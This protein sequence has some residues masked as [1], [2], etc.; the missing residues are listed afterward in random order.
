MPGYLTH[1]AVGIAVGGGAAA[2]ASALEVAEPD[3]ETLAPLAAI[4]VLAAVFPDV[5]TPSKART[6]VYALLLASALALMLAEEF[7][8][9]SVVGV[10]GM[11]P[12]L[13]MHR[14]WTHSWL[15]MLLIPA[16]ICALPLLVHEVEPEVLV[17]P[18]S[19]AVLGYGSHLVLDKVV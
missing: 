11:L 13:G 5:D 10:A 7:L 8:W 15:S 16:G 9:A 12:G 19:F 17:M 4:S 18:Y 2:A 14:G 3:V 1:T 6:L